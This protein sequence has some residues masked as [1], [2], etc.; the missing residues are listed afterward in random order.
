[1]HKT[2]EERRCGEEKAL[3]E[4][5]SLEAGYRKWGKTLEILNKG[6]KM[7]GIRGGGRQD[8]GHKNEHQQARV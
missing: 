8:E 2:G 7:F 4:S 3:G 5:S 6:R 1:L